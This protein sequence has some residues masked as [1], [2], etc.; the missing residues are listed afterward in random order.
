VALTMRRGMMLAIA[1]LALAG[2]LLAPLLYA[3]LE[4]G[5]LLYGVTGIDV[6]NHQ[7]DIDWRAVAADGVA[8]AYIKAT[9]GGDFG[10]RRFQR[11]WDGAKAAG[12]ERGAYHFFTQCRSGADQAANFIRTVPKGAGSLPPVIDAEHMGQC[13]SGPALPDVRGEMLAFM[14]LVESHYGKRPI[15][16]TTGEFH[17]AY[18][19]GHLTGER[20]WMRSLF[21]PPAI[22]RESWVLW[23][24]HHRGSRAG[25]KGPVDLNAFRGSAA[26]L[27]ALA[28]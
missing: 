9:E 27:A 25:I 28:R 19:A 12:I 1:A 17:D 5:P 3:R 26:D 11:N 8:F 15:I 23:Q 2:A 10:D 20:F 6:S 18:L 7:G 14:S 22:R 16:Y 13:R 24:Y 21:W 4:T